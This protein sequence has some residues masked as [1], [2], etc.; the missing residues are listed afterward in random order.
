[1]L[2][3]EYS[4]AKTKVAEEQKK[5]AEAKAKNAWFTGSTVEKE[6][7]HLE[8]SFGSGRKIAFIS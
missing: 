7:P 1:M 2:T 5:K 4:E 3:E 6:K 8:I